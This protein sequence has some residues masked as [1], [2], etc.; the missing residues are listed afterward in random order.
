MIFIE[1]IKG[2]YSV[3]NK[4]IGCDLCV[5]IAPD[6]FTANADA[7]IEYGFCYVIKQ[8]DSDHE[9]SLCAEAAD[10]C[11]ADAIT[12]KNAAY[13]DSRQPKGSHKK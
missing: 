13:K 2:P 4:C 3:T 8:P 12:N 5:A 9:Q 7:A 1:N 10:I 11:P 6:N